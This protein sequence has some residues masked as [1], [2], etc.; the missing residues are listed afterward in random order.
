VN[1][2][3]RLDD[4]SAQHLDHDRV[5]RRSLRDVFRSAVAG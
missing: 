4:V 3:T 2:V 5:H 1:V